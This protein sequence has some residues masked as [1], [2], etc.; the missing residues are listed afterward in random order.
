MTT[1]TTGSPS[2]T[3]STSGISS[4]ALP[5]AQQNLANA[6]ALTQQP[7]QPYQGQ[8]NAAM[9]GLQNQS[10]A[11]AQ[12]LGVNQNSIQ[13]GNV[14]GQAAQGLLNTNY[15]PIQ[16]GYQNVNAPQLNNYQMN[17]PGNVNAPQLNN[18]QMNGPG[19][20]YSQGWNNQAANQLMNPYVMQSLNPQLQLLQQQQ[21]MQ[22]TQN[23]SQATQAGAFGGSRF[24]IQQGLQNQSNQLAQNSLVGNAL[25]T[26]YTNAQQQFNTQNAASLQAQQANQQ[27]R[28][29]TN[30]GN[31]SAALQTQSLG[32]G[33]NLAAQQANQ[34]AGLATNQGNLSAAL[35]TQSLGA[36]QNL[37]AQQ[38][39]Q[40]AGLT[41]QQA[42]INQQ[43]FGA[44]LGLQGL[45]SAA[46]AAATQNNIGQTQSNQNNTNIALQNQLG[47]Q[48]QAYQQNL[49][50]TQYQNFQNQLNYPYQQTSYINNLINGYPST[51]ST[52]TTQ[53]STPSYLQQGAALGVGA[54][55]VS[56]MFP[57]LG[58]GISTALGFANG[59]LM[60]SYKDGGQVKRMATGK[61]A[62]S[63]GSMSIVQKA[64]ANEE[65]AGH[66][67]IAQ[68][69]AEIFGLSATSFDTPKINTTIAGSGAAAAG[70]APGINAGA[71]QYQTPSVYAPT[72]STPVQ[73]SIAPAAGAPTDSSSA[74]AG[75]PTMQDLIAMKK[76]A[77]QQQA[78]QTA[79]DNTDAAAANAQSNFRQS[80][81]AQQ[82]QPV[83][84]EA[85]GGLQHV[86][87]SDDMAPNEYAT[88]GI[89]DVAR[90]ADNG[91]TTS[92]DSLPADIQKADMGDNSLDLG[93]PSTLNTIREARGLPAV[94]V[95]QVA[96]AAPAPVQNPASVEL[97]KMQMM[98]QLVGNNNVP[99]LQ[100]A[101]PTQ[102]QGQVNPASIA[103]APQAAPQQAPQGYV[104][105]QLPANISDAG[106]R[107]QAGAAGYNMLRQAY[108]DINGQKAPTAE[109]WQAHQDKIYE[110]NKKLMGDSPI[111]D[112]IRANEESKKHNADIER[113][114]KGLALIA[115]MPDF[116]EGNQASRGLARG[117]SSAAKGWGSAVMNKDMADAALDKM[118]ATL[119]V[120]QR[121]EQQ[122]QVKLASDANKQFFEEQ[123][124]FNKYIAESRIKITEGEGKLAAEEK[125]FRPNININDRP[126][127]ARNY[128]DDV[129]AIKAT[130]KET[131]KAAGITHPETWY[132]SQARIQARGLVSTG[133]PGNLNTTNTAL[134]KEQ[135]AERNTRIGKALETW[136]SAMFQ[137][138]KDTKATYKRY[139]DNYGDRA[140]AMYAKDQ[141]DAI[142]GKSSAAPA[143]NAGTPREVPS[144]DILPYDVSSKQNPTEA[145]HAKLKPGENFYWNGQLLSKG[146]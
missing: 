71:S 48:Q 65:N 106:I 5:Y 56:Q 15:N 137:R 72:G 120:A 62:N 83:A 73:R 85:Q 138:G 115:S 44:G 66:D 22:A 33:Q 19:N 27:A 18:Y 39:N 108:Q 140:G 47:T 112:L 86:Y 25:N 79:Q 109:D 78:A 59:G 88:G 28:L 96:Q 89:T 57:N 117:I 60:S 114:Q 101:A 136:N 8:Q 36:G 131:D 16:A 50:N 92:G 139:V 68:G 2:S 116:L 46:Q 35:Q 105:P 38:A 98:R 129:E 37:A 125:G 61:T 40:N 53:P 41:A 24:G 135:E 3:T 145:Q 54:Y 146:Q 121:A 23:A 42:N 75:L 127:S 102:A 77:A 45:Q 142:E 111:P 94:P 91:V 9:T 81:I 130:L 95:E 52:S 90:Y 80:E 13:A 124:K 30:Q 32:A 118:N 64:I 58:S 21:G 144:S 107:N 126:S 134:T 29:A 14:A 87:L 67:D 11:Q 1:L 123:D 99:A 141:A 26:A 31:L 6:W 113:V 93:A 74:S 51:S 34:N 132:E 100:Q 119:K 143:P 20:V 122:G 128:Q 4:F 84:S 12:N 70:T 55:G 82:E 63:S 49:L 69:L 104:P 103:A 17:G 97:Q 43:Q 10:F 76:Q 7:Y 133:M 110:H